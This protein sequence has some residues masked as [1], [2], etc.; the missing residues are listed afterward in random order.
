M[1]IRA[2]AAS[3]VLAGI[4]LPAAVAA[5]DTAVALVDAA[6]AA[7][8]P[9]AAPVPQALRLTAN[10]P[11][12]LTLNSGLTT[13]STLTGTKFSMTVAQDVVADG[14]VVVPKGSR[15]IGLV[16]YAKKNGSFG[17]S[18]KME[19]AF[20]YIEVGG[21]Q[22]P[23]DGSFYQEGEGNTMGTVGAVFAAGIIGGAVVKG[24]EVDLAEGRDFEAR[25]LKDVPFTS[26]NGRS[27]VDSAFDPGIISMQTLTEK[28]YK[29]KVKA[30]KKAAKG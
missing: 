9:V 27:A 17:K 21:R 11:V 14:Q 10:T 18:G 30:A 1:N 8:V 28:E 7:A 29:A 5:Q 15:A 3:A 4:L 23:L 24:K 20:K 13:R 6:P 2:F 16:T 26:L 12:A 19:L 22:I 25:V